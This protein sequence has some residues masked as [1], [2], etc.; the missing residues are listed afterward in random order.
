MDT[1]DERSCRLRHRLVPVLLGLAA[2]LLPSAAG[3]VP[4]SPA[5]CGSLSTPLGGGVLATRPTGL[6]GPLRLYNLATGH[7]LRDLPA[8]VL[9]ASGGRHFA[10]V[11]QTLVGYDVRSGRVVSREAAGSG[12]QLAGVSG[13]G[14]TAVLLHREDFKTQFSIRGASPRTTSSS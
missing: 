7:R 11:R 12:W 8:G 6:A 14:Q 9:S 2:A 5:Q 3:G 4:C 13:D 1:S 10:L